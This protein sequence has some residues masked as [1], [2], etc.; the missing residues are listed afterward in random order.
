MAR[1]GRLSRCNASSRFNTVAWLAGLMLLAVTAGSAAA[2]GEPPVGGEGLKVLPKRPGVELRVGDRMIGTA[3]PSQ[4]L[5]VTRENGDW[6]WV[7]RGWIERKETVTIAEAPAFFTAEIEREPSA[8]AYASRSRAW[9]QDEHFDK[10]L[11]D[12]ESALRLDPKS[13]V[14]YKCRGRVKLAMGNTRGA[15]DDLNA[16]LEI[17]PKLATALNYR[18]QAHLK[19]GSYERAI[20]DATAA[21]GLDSSI[22]VAYSIRGRALAGVSSYERAVR[23]F[24]TLLATDPNYLPAL[25][26]RGNALLKLARYKECIGD[27]NKALAIEPRADLYY[28]RALARIHLSQPQPA[29]EDLTAAIQLDPQAAAAYYHR[30]TLYRSLGEKSKAAADLAESKRLR[31]VRPSGLPGKGQHTA[32]L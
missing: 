10:A 13:A 22:M 20:A 12:A 31:E 30:A 23:D 19:A 1:F 29:I 9:F 32:S 25:N 26:N 24:S 21:I 17:D 14:S 3:T 6:L 2:A 11:A 28:N 16:A 18:A 27:Y 8:F 7:G 15:I 4:M 5:T